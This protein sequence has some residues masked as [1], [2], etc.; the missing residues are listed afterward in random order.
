MK[1]IAEDL[2][3]SIRGHVVMVCE[4]RWRSAAVRHRQVMLRVLVNG[5]T[6]NLRAG[7]Q[8]RYKQVD[9]KLSS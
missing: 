3:R 5:P 7:R 8:G 6:Q 1:E 4:Q 2:L 9:R